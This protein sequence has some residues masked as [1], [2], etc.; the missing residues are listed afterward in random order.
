MKAVFLLALVHAAALAQAPPF[1][2]PPQPAAPQA[3]VTLE[4]LQLRGNTAIASDELL[5]VAAPYLGRPLDAGDLESLRLALT[6][7]YTDAG[8]INSGALIGPQALQG[9]VLTIDIHEGRLGQVRVRGMQGL[10]DDYLISRLAGD[11]AV[12]FNMEVLRERYALA[13]DDPL[14]Q[15]MHARVVPGAHAGA[16]ILDID[17]E[18]ARP[19]QLSAYANNYRPPSVGAAAGGLKGTLRNLSGWGDA[20]EASLQ[21]P[22]RGSQRPR[23]SLG[24]TMP[25]S[26]KT[27]LNLQWDHGQASVLE[28]P[29]RALDIESKLDSK[30]I[31]I[32][33]VLVHALPRKLTLGLSLGERRNSTTLAGLP[34]SFTPGEPDGTARVRAWRLWQEGVWR[35]STQVLALRATVISSRNNT[36]TVDGLPDGGP[37]LPAQRA[38]IWQA[39]GQYLRPLSGNGSALT[40]R[41][42]LQWSPHTLVALDRMALGGVASV[43]GYREN[44]L[45]R[46][47]GAAVTVELDV[48]VASKG[49][50]QLAV[51]PFA[52]A[53]RAGNRGEPGQSL[54]S[55]G[56]GARLRWSALAIDVAYA[57]RLLRPGGERG[58][59][60]QDRG[61]HAQVSYRFL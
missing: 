59:N 61:I 11:T 16:A 15:R 49:A 28:E 24:W 25:F 31:G 47:R 41:L 22:A 19:W 20:L 23:G 33:H 1:K 40:V 10:R 48:P 45:V 52:D 39:Q 42:N 9:K 38:L 4:A 35:T 57:R 29:L 27:S 32:S 54:A 7:R 55:L 13:L 5:R 30:E 18:R 60:L 17:V 34:F 56:V 37:A 14:F 21:V 6:A 8:Y 51:L 50:M 2:L 44:Q 58:A 12:P 46:D 3:L 43:R 53:G 36:R 26:G